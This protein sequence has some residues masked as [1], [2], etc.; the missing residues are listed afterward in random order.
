M[1]GV[2]WNIIE[3]MMWCWPW[4]SHYLI[5]NPLEE[6]DRL[7]YKQPGFIAV[8]RTS[9]GVTGTGNESHTGAILNTPPLMNLCWQHASMDCQHKLHLRAAYDCGTTMQPGARAT[10]MHGALGAPPPSSWWPITDQM[11]QTK[12]LECTAYSSDWLHGLTGVSLPLNLMTSWLCRSWPSSWTSSPCHLEAAGWRCERT[13]R[14]IE[15]ISRGSTSPPG[16]LEWFG[17][18]SYSGSLPDPTQTCPCWK[19]WIEHQC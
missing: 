16:G 1:L 15:E 18:T 4:P 5:I 8:G 14:P 11:N 7:L 10:R 3:N 19:K 2:S 17:R 12:S 6:R 9:R 13:P